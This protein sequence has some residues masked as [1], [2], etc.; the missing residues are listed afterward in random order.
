MSWE[1]H[2][3]VSSCRC[4]KGEI[5]H[6]WRSDDWGRSEDGETQLQCEYCRAAG[7]IVVH[8]DKG[9][10]IS[11]YVVHRDQWAAFQEREARDRIVANQRHEEEQRQRH[12]ANEEARARLGGRLLAVVAHLGSKKALWGVLKAI[13]FSTGCPSFAA[14]DRLV[15]EVGRHE[16]VRRMV[17]AENQ[18][19]VEAIIE[20]AMASNHNTHINFQTVVSRTW[21]AI[22]VAGQITRL[23][24]EW[25]VAA[26]SSDQK[27]VRSTK[28]ELERL[29][30]KAIAAVKN[31]GW[32]TLIHRILEEALAPVAAEVV[33]IS[34]IL[35]TAGW[36]SVEH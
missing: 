27:T 3:T 8:R 35:K 16:A 25:R 36:T 28:R 32:G 22:S 13:H 2:R 18:Q 20:A 1:D 5:V 23:F 29:A 33:P 30:D 26:N 31:A 12:A 34:T 6:T 15:R 19:Y 17:T 14:F 10:Y 9:K 24:N 4:G 7:Y 21:E 11:T